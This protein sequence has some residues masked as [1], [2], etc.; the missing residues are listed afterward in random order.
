MPSRWYQVAAAAKTLKKG[1]KNLGKGPIAVVVASSVAFMLIM[2]VAFVVLRSVIIGVACGWV[3][4]AVLTVAFQFGARN[5]V[6]ATTQGGKPA[7]AGTKRIQ[8]TAR[9][10]AVVVGLFTLGMFG[11]EYCKDR[12]THRTSCSVQCPTQTQFLTSS[13]CIPQ[14]PHWSLALCC[15][16]VF[17]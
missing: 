5:I 2:I 3:G 7:S 10:F 6:Q 4:V 14:L 15:V 16:F 9:N 11:C 17:H 12:D 1:K 13:T 8:R